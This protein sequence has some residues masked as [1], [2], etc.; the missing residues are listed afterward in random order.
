MTDK[1][2]EEFEAWF[3]SFADIDVLFD[4]GG[5]AFAIDP[6]ITYGDKIVNTTVDGEWKSWKA[7]RAALC[8][9]L[10]SR[11]SDDSDKWSVGYDFGVDMAADALDSAGVRYK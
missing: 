11:I 4:D 9:E 7:S 8:V 3:K 2:R 10:P 5:Q 6:P 1:M